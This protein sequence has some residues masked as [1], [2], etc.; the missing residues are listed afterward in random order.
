MDFD[1][2][3]PKDFSPVERVILNSLGKERLAFRPAAPREIIVPKRI[4]LQK[5]LLE[6]EKIRQAQKD[7]V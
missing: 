4:A 7:S 6:E 1:R 2:A 3:D 5:K